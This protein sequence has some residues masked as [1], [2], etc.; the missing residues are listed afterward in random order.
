MASILSTIYVPFLVPSLTLSS[1]F[2]FFHNIFVPSKKAAPKK[3][4]TTT[5]KKT[6]AK[7]K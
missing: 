3:K 7:K 2:R 5:K 4:K 1:L 6:A